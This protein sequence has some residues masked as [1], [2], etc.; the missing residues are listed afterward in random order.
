MFFLLPLISS[1]VGG[2]GT[3][4]TVS[5]AAGVASTALGGAAL[6][7]AALSMAAQ[8]GGKIAADKLLGAA[9]VVVST[10]TAVKSSRRAKLAEE[11][12]ARAESQTRAAEAE[13][14]RLQAEI[15]WLQVELQTQG[16]TDEDLRDLMCLQSCRG[17]I[18]DTA[19]A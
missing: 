2:I 12:C 5:S 14:A 1:V 8:T 17:Y 10:G 3:V 11:R 18:R 7:A 19:H 9:A 6:G 4:V 15:A 16:E 13:I